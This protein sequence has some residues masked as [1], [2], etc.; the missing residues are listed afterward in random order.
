METFDN[1]LE[2]VKS[3]DAPIIVTVYGGVATI[4]FRKG[5][6]SIK[7]SLIDFD[8]LEEEGVDA[9]GVND[10]LKEHYV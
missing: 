1:L 10:W 7:V 8:N 2:A 5:S 3:E 4:L 9:D 6:P